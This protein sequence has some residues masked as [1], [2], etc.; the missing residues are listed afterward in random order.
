[1]A[2]LDGL[3]DDYADD[4]ARRDDRWRVEA[5]LAE[6]LACRD[7]VAQRREFG[8]LLKEV[9]RLEANGEPPRSVPPRST[10]HRNARPL[11][12]AAAAALLLVVA[13][14]WL[15]RSRPEAGEGAV[16][17]AAGN[18]RVATTQP[19]VAPA[20]QLVQWEEASIERE[21]SAAR[22]AAAADVLAGL[23]ATS[24][25]AVGAARFV[26]ETFPDTIAG[27]DAARRLG[28]SD[29]P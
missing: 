2:E 7:Y 25:Y 23:P 12:L 1:M 9:F 4:V 29:S 24:E 8:L 20:E 27:R 17:S 18:G 22:L 28:A 26:A 14:W 19:S 16:A 6:C 15:G 13:G 3:L 5:H 11:A 10:P 21:A